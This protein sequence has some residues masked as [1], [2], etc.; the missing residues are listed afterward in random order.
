M[1][2]DQSGRELTARGVLGLLLVLTRVWVLAVPALA[3]GDGVE[4]DLRITW[5][6][7]VEGQPERGK[8]GGVC[9]PDIPRNVLS[10]DIYNGLLDWTV[11]EINL[12]VTWSPYRDDDKRAYRIHLALEPL[13]ADHVTVRLGLQLPPDDVVQGKT[14][15]HW[16]WQ[17][18]AAKGY[19]AN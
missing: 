11:S 12:V 1:R 7:F 2:V 19:R 15:R 10:C 3:Q 9:E 18:V 16:G 14:F 6:G 13:K 17:I 5:G 4:R 8:V